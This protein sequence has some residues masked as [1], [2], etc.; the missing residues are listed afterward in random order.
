[1]VSPIGRPHP[2]AAGNRAHAHRGDAMASANQVIA[3]SRSNGT[4]IFA[5][6]D[7]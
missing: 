4:W 3:P 5:G 2:L 1:M 6:S 7:S